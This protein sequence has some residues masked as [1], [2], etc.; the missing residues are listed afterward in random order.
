MRRGI[1]KL[2]AIGIDETSYRKGHVDYVTVIL[3]KDRDR[4][5]IEE[6]KKVAKTV[7]NYFWGLMN[8][9][10]LRVSNGM[11]EAKNNC[12]QRIKKIAC[13]TE[14][15]GFNPVPLGKF[16]HNRLHHLTAGM[17]VI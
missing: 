1:C 8:A 10:R 13:E 4:V 6:M 17:P 9:I 15:Y 3:D 5:L 12:I 7:R 14:I 16:G 2:K 11:L